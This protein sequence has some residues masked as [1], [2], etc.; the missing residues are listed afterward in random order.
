MN[1]IRW[2]T[3]RLRAVVARRALERDMQE[4]MREHLERATERYV[5]RGM[6]TAD[7]RRAARRE[8]GNVAVLQEEAR[9]A[10]DARWVEALIADT[11]FAFRYFARHRGPTD[12]H[13]GAR[14]RHRR[15]YHVLLVL[16][17]TVSS[18]CLVVQGPCERV[19]GGAYPVRP[20]TTVAR[21][22]AAGHRRP[23]CA[24]EPRPGHAPKAEKPNV[25]SAFADVGNRR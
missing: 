8:F 5:A 1:P 9:D 22:F 3:L 12:H 6:S 4:E 11:R 18:R 2:T 23:L 19:G 10:R 25:N 13:H 16:P 17:A 20:H 14:A 24:A 7:A 15:Q 21:G